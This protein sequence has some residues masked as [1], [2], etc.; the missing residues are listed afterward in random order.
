MEPVQDERARAAREREDSSAT[1]AVG[2][3]DGSVYLHHQTEPVPQLVARLTE[4]LEPPAIRGHLVMCLSGDISPSGALAACMA[5]PHDIG[6]VHTA[7]DE[8]TRRADEDARRQDTL[9]RDRVDE[10]TRLLVELSEG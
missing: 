4:G 6:V 7:I 8:I 2:D 9:V 10:L 5:E 1:V 3:E